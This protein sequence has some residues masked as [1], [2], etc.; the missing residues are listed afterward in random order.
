MGGMNGI[1]LLC[2]V[3]KRHPHVARVLMSGTL[4]EDLLKLRAGQGCAQFVFEKPVGMPA[5]EA[6]LATSLGIVAGGPADAEDAG[7]SV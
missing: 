6:I 2:L 5:W 4:Q 3:R 1:E 7:A